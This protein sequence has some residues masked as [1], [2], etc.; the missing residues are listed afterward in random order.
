[1]GISLDTLEITNQQLDI[2]T[3]TTVKWMSSF[4]F[5][6]VVLPFLF[7]KLK[8]TGREEELQ[9]VQNGCDGLDLLS[10]SYVSVLLYASLPY[11]SALKKK[12]SN[13]LK[14]RMS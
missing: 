9:I 2:D 5:L 8:R 11:S 14:N 10:Y 3:M 1:M 7:Y 6:E 12:I 4:F 13:W